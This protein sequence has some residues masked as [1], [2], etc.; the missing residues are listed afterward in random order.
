VRGTVGRCRLIVEPWD[1]LDSVI[2]WT[3]NGDPI[4][5][6]L[7]ADTTVWEGVLVQSGE[8]RVE[9]TG[10]GRL[11]V[12]GASIKVLPRDWSW[13]SAQ[14]SFQQGAPGDLD[15]C[16][17][18]FAG[19]V[20]DVYGCTAANPGIIINPGPNAGFSILPAGGPNQ[21]A[22]YVA[23]PT[24]RM[25]LRSQIARK[26]RPDGALEALLGE[27][28]VV[29]ACTDVYAPNAVPPQNNHSVNTVCFDEPEFY[30][31]VAHIWDHETQHLN[32]AKAEAER[33]E[34]D[35]YGLWESVVGTSSALAFEAANGI[36]NDMA[37][38]VTTEANKIHVPN[39]H[40]FYIWYMYPVGIWDIAEVM[41]PY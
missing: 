17:G 31:L 7:G 8:V 16:M 14:R 23:N 32:L 11:H 37:E 10:R 35:I 1:A 5:A 13:S 19:L 26:Y 27:P 12:V 41:F 6:N 33:P 34:W 20:A 40:Y 9:F 2:V 22:W 24:T 30:S 39:P 25:D 38:A 3:F 4:H 36:Q 21:G 18:S 29:A 28:D 15:N